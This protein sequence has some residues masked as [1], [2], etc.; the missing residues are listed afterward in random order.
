[1]SNGI[2]IA[3]GEMVRRALLAVARHA[4]A[5]GLPMP[6]KRQLAKVIGISEVQLWRHQARLIA[7]GALIISDK[8][9]RHSRIH[10]QEV[11]P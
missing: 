11:R 4:Q 5:R 3:R 9:T 6:S 7:E 1:M 8:R 2:N 10:I